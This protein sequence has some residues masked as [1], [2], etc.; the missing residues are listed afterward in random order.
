MS[1][2]R[3]WQWIEQFQSEA[4]L[5]RHI[6]V[7]SIQFDLQLTWLVIHQRLPA[8]N[9][10]II[11]LGQDNIVGERTSRASIHQQCDFC[12]NLCSVTGS[13]GNQ[14]GPVEEV[15]LYLHRFVSVSKSLHCRCD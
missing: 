14:V 11:L 6:T 2:L 4:A 15:C 1:C 8:E 10:T 13:R 12:D 9:G 3:C 7:R 5:S